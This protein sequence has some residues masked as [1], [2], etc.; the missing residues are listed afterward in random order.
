[1]RDKI[2][3]E[4]TEH[5]A[6]FAANADVELAIGEALDQLTANIDEAE[7]TD[8]ELLQVRNV[9]AFIAEQE[10]LSE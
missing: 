8:A 2:I 6:K 4:L 7:L 1:M 10:R 5:M 9:R 3:A